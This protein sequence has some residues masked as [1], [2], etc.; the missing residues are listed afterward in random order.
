ML[1]VHAPLSA[2][3]MTFSDLRLFRNTSLEVLLSCITTPIL[4]TLR[5]EVFLSLQVTFSHFMRTAKNLKLTTAKFKFDDTG[6]G[7]KV[8]SDEGVEYL[9]SLWHC[10]LDEQVSSMA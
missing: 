7:V 3:I 1:P 4:E 2:P 10:L 5:L 6:I 9:P 8:Y